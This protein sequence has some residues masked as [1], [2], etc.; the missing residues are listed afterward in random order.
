MTTHV[1]TQY[2]VHTDVWAISL[3]DIIWLGDRIQWSGFFMHNQLT[4]TYFLLSLDIIMV[5]ASHCRGSPPSGYVRGAVRIVLNGPPDL[6]SLEHQDHW[7]KLLHHLTRVMVSHAVDHTPRLG[8]TNKLQCYKML[9]RLSESSKKIK[10]FFLYE[11]PSNALGNLRG[12]YTKRFTF[13]KDIVTA[14]TGGRVEMYMYIIYPSKLESK[15][16]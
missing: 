7:L 10:T 12:F 4:Y 3:Y 15:D 9:K 13:W 5:L 11:R 2:S 1:H 16:Q 8:R 14:N 6:F